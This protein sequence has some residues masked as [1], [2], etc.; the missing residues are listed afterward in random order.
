MHR[1]RLHAHVSNRHASQGD[2]P[3]FLEV[4]DEPRG[5]QASTSVIVSHVYTLLDRVATDFASIRHGVCV[6]VQRHGV[7]T[8]DSG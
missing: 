8:P 1:L 3:Q 4:L 2:R 5:C 6:V 7:F